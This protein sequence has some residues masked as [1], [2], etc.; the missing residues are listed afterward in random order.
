MK[1]RVISTLRTAPA[2]S[3]RSLPASSW[4]ALEKTKLTATYYYVGTEKDVLANL[5]TGKKSNTIG[6]EIDFYVDQEVVDN[7]NLKTGGCLPVYR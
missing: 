7:L 4:Q 6:N 3:G 2:T 1:T 5:N